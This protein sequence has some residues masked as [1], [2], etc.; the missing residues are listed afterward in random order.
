MTKHELADAIGEYC[1]AQYLGCTLESK[2]PEVWNYGY[3]NEVVNLVHEF[4]QTEEGK[5]ALKDFKESD[6]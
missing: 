4:F 6:G 5:Q 3:K 1:H 2:T